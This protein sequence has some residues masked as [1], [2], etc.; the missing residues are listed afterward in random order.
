MPE[1]SLHGLSS[2]IPLIALL[3][4]SPAS[5]AAHF[6]DGDLPRQADLGFQTDTQDGALIA[7]QVTAAGAAAKSG[8]RDGDRIVAI[9][10]RRVGRPYEAEA[11]LVAVKGG[12]RV[13]MQ[14]ERKATQN[15]ASSTQRIVFTPPPRAFEDVPG[16]DSYYG[17]VQTSDGSRLRTIVTRPSATQLSNRLPVILLTQWVSCSS[18]EFSRG[19]LSR[20]ILKALARRS[21]AAL[22]RVERAGTGDSAGP[23]CHQL[24]YDTEVA[25]YREALDATLSHYAWLDPQRVVI[26]GSSLGTTEAPLVA[27]G[28][29]VAGVMVQGGGALTYLERMINFD[30]QQLERTNVPPDQIDERMRRQTQFNVEYLVKGRSPDEIVRDGPD[31]VAARAGIRGLGDGEHY[32]RPYAWHRQASR[33]NF[34]AAWDRLDAPVLVLYGEF[35]QFET[36]HGHELIAQIVN[37]RHPGRATFVVVP[38]MD[39]EGDVYDTI[40]DAYAWRHPVSGPPERAQQLQTGPMLRWLKDVVGF[41]VRE[42]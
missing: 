40:E 6:V 19:G 31:M 1:R 29:R 10:G 11:Q 42:E 37:K 7:M 33:R 36:R 24:D 26:Y 4:S 16:L 2:V 5:R 39:H 18:L 21:G 15:A 8:L 35:D 23:A 25:H 12:Q 20:E 30:R 28:R 27:E 17:V 38:H 13:E 41:P 9:D 22:I 3:L 32:G 34:A 14:L